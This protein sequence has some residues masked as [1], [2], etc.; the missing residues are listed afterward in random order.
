MISFDYTAIYV[1]AYMHVYNLV[2]LSG[3]GDCLCF[4]FE[5]MYVGLRATTDVIIPLVSFASP[6]AM[7]PVTLIQTKRLFL[8]WS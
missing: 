7:P 1:Y 4:F 3:V 6:S 8:K 5:F 2:L